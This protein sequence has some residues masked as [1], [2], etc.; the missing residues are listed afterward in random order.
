MATSSVKKFSKGKENMVIVDLAGRGLKKLESLPSSE[1]HST[2][3]T[4]ILDHNGLS[5]ID[6]LQEFKNLQQLSV[7]HN[8]L[9]RM[10]GVS[11]LP[12]IRVLN[13]PNN[14]IQTIEGLRELP[15][16]EWLNLSG[17]SIK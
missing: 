6:N 8:R 3:T 1:T 16:L 9:V 14:S 10:N 12:T 11:R 15:H 17:N 13:L 2:C 5:R 7:G 4:L